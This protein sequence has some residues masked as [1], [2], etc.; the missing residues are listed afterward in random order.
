M[1]SRRLRRSL[2]VTKS[3]KAGDIINGENVR[4]IRPNGGLPPKYY[5][6]IMG[7]IFRESCEPGTP[8]RFDLID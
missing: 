2:Y 1:E 5:D 7:K 8:L 3:V 6:E 4:A